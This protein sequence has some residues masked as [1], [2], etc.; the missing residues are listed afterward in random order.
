MDPK[1]H[2]SP[3]PPPVVH[4]DVILCLCVLSFI[5]VR[6]LVDPAQCAGGAGVQLTGP[7]EAGGTGRGLPGPVAVHSLPCQQ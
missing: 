6:V 7:V 1:G 2:N 5:F 4:R 3:P